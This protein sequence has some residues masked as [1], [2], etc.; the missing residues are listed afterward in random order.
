LLKDNDGN[1]WIATYGG[2]INKYDPKSDKFILYTTKDGLPGNNFYGLLED[3]NS[4]LWFSSSAGLTM[5]DIKK[6]TFTNYDIND[7]L[8][9]NE[10]NGGSYYKDENGLLFFGGVNG[11]NVFNPR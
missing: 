10:F 5:Y 6:K 8:Q 9:S 3:N 4:N 7:G 1:I 11:F 2:G